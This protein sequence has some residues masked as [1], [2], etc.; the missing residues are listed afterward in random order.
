MSM[1]F[2][3]AGVASAAII[4]EMVLELTTEICTRSNIPAFNLDLEDTKRRTIAFL[5]QGHYTAILGLRDGVPVAVACMAESY[6][7][8]AG[9]KIGIIQECYVRPQHR[10]G[11]MGTALIGAVYAHGAGRGWACVELCTP[12]LPAFEPTLRFYQRQGLEPV[13]GRKMRAYLDVPA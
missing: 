3:L 2:E 10:S 8:Y 13:G 11:G 12:P 6:A 9:G 5:E 1:Q 4:A 7:L